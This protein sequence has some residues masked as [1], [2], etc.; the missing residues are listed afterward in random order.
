ML[1]NYLKIALTVLKRRPFFTFISLFGISFT[2]FVVTVLLALIDHLTGS[3]YPE[4]NRDRSLYVQT[5]RLVNSKTGRQTYGQ[6][7][8]WYFEQ[9]VRGMKTPEA[10]SLVSMPV[11]HVIYQ[12]SQKIRTQLK[13]VDA[14]FWQVMQF[15]FLDGTPITPERY[16]QADPV[17]VISRHVRDEYFA[18]ETESVVGKT[19]SVNQQKLRIVGVV[20]DVPATR[21]FSSAGIYIPFT[22]AP[23]IR[24]NRGHLGGIIAILMARNSSDFEAIRAEYDQ[25]V[26]TVSMRD[27]REYDVFES[28][29]ETYTNGFLKGFSNGAVTIGFLK[30]VLAVFIGLFLFLPA[31]NLINI[32]V[33]RTLERA[34]EIGVRKA[35]GAS[36]RTLALQFVVENVFVTLLG[37]TISI[38]V[39]ALLLAWLN[40]SGLLPYSDLSIS[41]NVVGWS[42]GICLVF[43]VI[44]GAYPAWRLSKLPI[45]D[46]LK[47]LS[48]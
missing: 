16:Q 1:I 48:L 18:N 36:R 5:V 17:A 9:Y 28:S 14:A 23:T 40:H 26:K 3:Y 2:L 13:Y 30:T 27:N 20:D 7:S 34:S 22:A 25:I 46:A 33:S 42:L 21:L 31:L 10:V 19:I 8:Y 38:V 24:Q 39:S 43:G 45:V 11:P 12:G 6:G 44:S 37:G 32:N 47:G 35:F 41:L 29:A 4:Q 15:D